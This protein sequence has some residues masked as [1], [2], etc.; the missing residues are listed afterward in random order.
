M[1]M[2]CCSGEQLLSV[3]QVSQFLSVPERT[4]RHWAATQ[5]LSARKVGKPWWFRWRDVAAS[6]HRLSRTLN[7]SPG[8]C[9]AA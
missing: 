4:V 1:Q 3:H 6:E 7:V 8:G 5:V 9:H 2:R